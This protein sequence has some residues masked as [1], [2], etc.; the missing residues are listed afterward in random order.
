MIAAAAE[1]LD[2]WRF[3]AHPEVWLLVAFLT[4]AYIYMARVIGPKAVPAGTAPISTKQWV[5]FVGAIAVLWGASDWPV[6][7]IGEDY[8]YSAHM[9]QHMAFTLF[10]PPLALVATP[11]WMLRLLIGNGRLYRSLTWFARPLVMALLFNLM[12]MITHIPGVV[13][14]ST[15]NGVLHYSLHVLIV[16]TS[17]LMWMPVLGP[18]PEWQIGAG[19]KCIYLFMNSVIGMIPA[20]WLTF[21][22]GAVYRHYAQPIRVWGISVTD[23]QQ[24]AG[25]IMKTAGSLYLWG[26]IVFYFFTRFGRD[27][28]REYEPAGS[29]RTRRPSHRPDPAPTTDEPL[30]FETVRQAFERSAPPRDGSVEPEQPARDER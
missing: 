21:A 17:L 15:E 24:L 23:D 2:P 25:A 19:A 26:F 1:Q 3:Q 16:T 30:T 13:N 20:G 11:E 14:A 18:I 6:H 12:V 5:C 22:D 4:G 10:F 7:D 9:V 29:R 27:G 28:E 8:L